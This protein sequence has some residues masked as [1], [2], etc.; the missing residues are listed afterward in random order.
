MPANIF[1]NLSPLEKKKKKT[2]SF[3]EKRLCISW[4][5][6]TGCYEFGEQQSAQRHWQ[7]GQ[8]HGDPEQEGSSTVKVMSSV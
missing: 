5:I 1:P 4:E 6:M 3:V 8:N 2:G 7:V